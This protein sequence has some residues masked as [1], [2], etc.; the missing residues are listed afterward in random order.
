MDKDTALATLRKHRAELER[1]GIR[2]AALFGSVARGDSGPR[3]DLD[4]AIEID[5]EA[6]P[7]VYAYVGIKDRVT[8]LF[9][10]RVDVVN[11]AFLRPEVQENSAA[12][13]IYAF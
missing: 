7:D 8:A 12:D 3:S 4:I 2:H 10:G 6:L 1:L 9:E 11:R 5:A 13:L